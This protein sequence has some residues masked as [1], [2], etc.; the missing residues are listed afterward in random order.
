[1]KIDK[2]MPAWVTACA[3]G[4][5]Q[6]LRHRAMLLATT[7]L[8]A[9]APVAGTSAQDQ[10]GTSAQNQQGANAA[11]ARRS[12]EDASR[13]GTG[14][15]TTHPFNILP[16]ELADR[17]AAFGQQSGLQVVADTEVVENRNTGGVT[18]DLAP[19]T[20]LRQL[21]AGTGLAFR[22]ADED[23]VLIV[24]SA[25]QGQSGPLRLGPILVTG[26]RVER[27]VFETPS[28]VSVTTAADMEAD[29]TMRDVEDIYHGIPNV[30][31]TGTASDGPTIRG[32]D[33]TGPLIGA[34]AFLG[35][36]R[37]R[38][39]ITVDG[40]PLSYFEYTNG[41]ASLFD[42][43]RVEVFNGPQTTSQGV[44]SIA[45]ATHVVTA[46]PTFE[47]EAHG[48]AEYGTFENRRLS[49]AASGPVIDDELAVRFAADFQSR[50]SFAE[51]IP[52]IQN[53]DEDEFKYLT[54]RGKVLWEPL[55]VGELSTMLTV[56]YSSISEPQ[57]EFI[58]PP[59]ED[60]QFGSGTSSGFTSDILAVTHDASFDF[61]RNLTFSNRLTFADTNIERFAD[62]PA[63][64]A[65]LIKQKEYIEEAT[66]HLNGLDGR[67]SGVLGTSLLV[68]DGEDEID[69]T[70]FLGL[71]AFEDDHESVG[72][73][74]EATYAVTPRLDVTAGLRY[75]YD[76]QRRVGSIGAFA[77]DFDGAFDAF[78]PK[79][80][81]GYDVQDNIRVGAQVSRGFNPGGVTISFV[82]GAADTF[83]EETVW[84]YELF[85]RSSF[86]DD[87]LQ[88]N[89]NLF[90][91]DYYDF[92]RSE[93]VLV[94]AQPQ[95][96]IANADRARSYG[97]E[98]SAQYRP[99]DELRL[100]GGLGLL[101]TEITEFDNAVDPN[102]VG[103]EFP[104]A[105]HLTLAL[106]ADYEAVRD[107]T[108][109][110]RARFSSG[111]FSDAANT[112]QFKVN[113]QAV[114]D[115]VARYEIGGVEL[116]T[117]LDNAFNTVGPTSK[118]NLG[119]GTVGT[120]VTP[121]EFGVGI[122]ARF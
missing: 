13:N 116:Y 73:F 103:R 18:G 117:Y 66:L 82:T 115:F 27:S 100:F 77:L 74:G 5:V 112:D 22:F 42:V 89:A 107:L 48:Q 68:T 26:E 43:E 33:T 63:A 97:L 59:F 121:R 72:V 84:N 61:S 2:G 120:V 14:H 114:F 57:V 49:A 108:L 99:I 105:P 62:N 3:Q 16:G 79:L 45:G 7:C 86:L 24:A 29:P 81:V 4:E 69:L 101:D 8:V 47:T 119:G 31:E 34:N 9:M 38:A 94:G 15:A 80:A 90:Y 110:A 10:P 91:A 102:V 70:A 55:A 12:A 56:S 75:Q 52:P 37:P 20:A 21:L 51:G 39:T 6:R 17:L 78:L 58:A 109:G 96:E 95:L 35:G 30:T 104:R 76:H 46:N 11:E 53:F 98:L 54:L 19:A 118:V 83:D 36:S 32:I 44:N 113:S 71:G 64:G 106:G 60:L 40:R 1:M 65:A 92:Q 41:T 25:D 28:F 50:K 88:L 93:I 85:M 122:K 111:H 87:R 67:L 23:T